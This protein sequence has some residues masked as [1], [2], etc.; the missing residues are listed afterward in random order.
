MA[1]FWGFPSK[2]EYDR[3]RRVIRQVERMEAR[4]K[5]GRRVRG[6]GGGGGGEMFTALAASEI[7]AG[8]PSAPTSGTATVYE[9]DADGNTT[10][11]DSKTVYNPFAHGVKGALTVSRIDDDNYLICGFDLL[12]ALAARDNFGARK[13]LGTAAGASSPTDIKWQATVKCGEVV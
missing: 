13:Y 11:L 8:T 5:K 7:V 2:R 4:P 6:G 9:V 3:A 10:S 12:E 1:E